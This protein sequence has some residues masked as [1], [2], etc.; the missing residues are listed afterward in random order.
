MRGPTTAFTHRGLSPHQFTPM[1]GAHKA[2]AANPAMTSLF[3]AGRQWRGV[4]DAQRRPA[5]LRFLRC[6]IRTVKEHVAVRAQILVISAV[7]LAIVACALC[8]WRVAFM[9]WSRMHFEAKPLIIKAHSRVTQGGHEFYS[10]TD[11][12]IKGYYLQVGP[13]RIYRIYRSLIYVQPKK[14]AA[15]NPAITPPFHAGYQ[16]R[17][18][19]EFNRYWHHAYETATSK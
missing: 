9:G 14:P 17:G 5:T 19:S 7:S 13:L 15:A 3:H 2:R 18:A 4:A 1:S 10:H 8:G 12:L 6:L 11:E 16:R